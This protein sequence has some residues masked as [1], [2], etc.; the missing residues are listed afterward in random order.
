MG[1]LGSLACSRGYLLRLATLERKQS[2]RNLRKVTNQYPIRFVTGESNPTGM[3]KR[4][5]HLRGNAFLVE[6]FGA[7]IL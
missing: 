1:S 7:K 5:Y 6:V 3:R 4:K 2:T